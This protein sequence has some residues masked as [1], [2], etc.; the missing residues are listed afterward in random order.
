MS[1]CHACQLSC[2][3]ACAPCNAVLFRYYICSTC[4][5]FRAMIR[6][7]CVLSFAPPSHRL[8]LMSSLRALRAEIAEQCGA[9]YKSIEGTLAGYQQRRK[10]PK[11]T[12]ITLHSLDLDSCAVAFGLAIATLR[13]MRAYGSAHDQRPS[14]SLSSLAG[15]VVQSVMDHLEGRLDVLLEEKMKP[16]V[17]D[18]LTDRDM[19]P[20]LRA[21]IQHTIDTLWVSSNTAPRDCLYLYVCSAAS[22]HCDFCCRRRCFIVLRACPGGFRVNS[23][24]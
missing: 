12:S 13:C 20:C 15:R 16:W 4:G 22:S 8:G 19:P 11:T 17:E 5:V 2:L 9:R 6:H 1:L 23:E 7:C 14:V 24:L 3:S 10:G 18:R 21:S